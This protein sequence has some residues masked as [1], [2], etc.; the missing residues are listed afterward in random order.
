M[1]IIKKINNMDQ[2][3]NVHKGYTFFLIVFL[4]LL[5][6]CHVEKEFD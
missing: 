5:L 2:Q 3:H 1:T 6:V 4:P